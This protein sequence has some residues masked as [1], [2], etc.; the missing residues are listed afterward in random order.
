[1]GTPLPPNEPGVLC[2]RCWGPGKPFGPG[3]TPLVV[4]LSFLGLQRGE[5]WIDA[6]E[7]SLLAPH[8]LIQT[9]FPCS[10]QELTGTWLTVLAY[11]D[12][13]ESITLRHVPELRFAFISLTAPQCTL[14]QPNQIISP[15]GDYAFNGT[16]QITWDLEGLE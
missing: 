13:S 5:F 3:P 9:G 15:V 11:G 7:Q 2:T 8:S 6:D 10:W 4:R 1:M 14:G 16:V 12:V